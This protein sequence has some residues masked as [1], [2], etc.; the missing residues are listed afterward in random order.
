MKFAQFFSNTHPGHRILAAGPELSQEL[1]LAAM[2]AGVADYL[3]KPVTNGV[4]REAGV[5]AGALHGRRRV[6]GQAPGPALHPVQPQG[7]LGRHQRRHQPGGGAPPPHLEAHAAGG[8][9]SRAGRSR[10]P[11]RGPAAVQLRGHGAE[12]PPDGRRPARLVH[13]AARVGR[14]PA[15]GAVPSRAGGGAERGRDPAHPALPA[16]ALR[17]RRGGHA[18]DLLARHHG[19]AGPGRPGAAGDQRG[20]PVAPQHPARAAHAAAG[21][22]AGRRP[23]PSGHQPVSQQP[24]TSPCRTWSARSRS[25]PSGPSATTTTR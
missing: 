16:S 2:R 21:A 24:A 19:G 25:S 14:P 11:S 3:I 10:P 20:P 1:L 18:Q 4:L 8:P 15:L 9:R 22:A 13:R 12:L 6:Q 23:D 17:L 5:P 7:R